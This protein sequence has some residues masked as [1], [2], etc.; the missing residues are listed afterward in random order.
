MDRR[1]PAW[2]TL[3]ST[4]AVATLW[5]ACL[6]PAIDILDRPLDEPG[7]TSA[8]TGVALAVIVLAG[9]LA[10][11]FLLVA[12]SWGRSPR[13]HRGGL[14]VAGV[15][16]LASA[17]VWPG[18]PGTGPLYVAGTA[19]A[20]VAALAAALPA[21]VP[22][23]GDPDEPS[24][25]GPAA[26]PTGPAWLARA[27]LLVS[28]VVVL[29]GGLR[30]LAYWHW[31]VTL[32]EAHYVVAVALGAVMVLL[33]LI[34][35]RL[36]ARQRALRWVAVAVLVPLALLCL[37]IGLAV[38]LDT[39]TLRVP[40]EAEV[41]WGIG[42]PLVLLGSGLVAGAVAARRCWWQLAALSV[43]SGVLWCVLAVV[44]D[45]TIRHLV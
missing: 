38:L 2:A 7:S 34:G 35:P 1:W 12:A 33:A 8:G 17:V 6:S 44:R 27:A 28:G 32:N 5:V 39:S 3:W 14:V 16:L 13:V 23:R 20:G 37:A 43:S 41:G 29:A 26:S 15:A 30:G 25:A 18:V 4:W 21:V 11:C 42:T 10:L 22:G 9:V 45:A 40:E 36:A 19:L 31:M 24:Y